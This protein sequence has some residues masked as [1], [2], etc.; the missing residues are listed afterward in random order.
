MKTPEN[1]PQNWETVEAPLVNRLERLH[2]DTRQKAEILYVKAGLKPASW[3]KFDTSMN[4]PSDNP[5]PVEFY[6]EEDIQEYYDFLKQL[7]LPFK[8]LPRKIMPETQ[9]IS[10]VKT[11]IARHQV[12]TA[13]AHSPDDLDKLLM[14]IPNMDHEKLG[15]ALGYPPTAVKAFAENKGRAN[16]YKLPKEVLLS[17]AFI[18]SHT[19]TYSED[20]WQNEIQDGLRNAEFLKTVSPQIYN[21][22]KEKADVLYKSMGVLD[23][24]TR[25][26]FE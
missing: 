3:I 5:E 4:I 25:G 2:L 26:K 19:L 18:F 22:I 24:K 23:D 17:D 6:T 14:A 16:L 15:L 7:N 21:Q 10:G 11:E 8:I 1:S 13:V 9:R 12:E 20:N